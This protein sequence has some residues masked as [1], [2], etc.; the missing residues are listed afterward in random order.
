MSVNAKSIVDRSVGRVSSSPRIELKVRTER[1]SANDA[2]KLTLLS[3]QPAESGEYWRLLIPGYYEL[4]ASKEGYGSKSRI[5]SI[6]KTLDR[7]EIESKN[8]AV[9]EAE[10]VDFV[11]DTPG[12][13]LEDDTVFDDYVKY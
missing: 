3:I 2:Y 8:P 1:F 5:I 7:K 4:V 6:E 12:D 10:I 9:F 13:E 11:L